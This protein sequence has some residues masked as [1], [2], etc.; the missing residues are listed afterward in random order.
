MWAPV[1]VLAP[2]LPEPARI[3]GTAGSNHRRTSPQ[4]F[5][6]KTSAICLDLQLTLRRVET[7]KPTLNLTKNCHNK[8]P[9]KDPKPI[10]AIECT[11]GIN[12]Q[13]QM[14]RCA[15]QEQSCANAE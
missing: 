1:I 8:I 9:A 7:Q 5:F 11:K 4:Y 2:L 10:H 12:Y 6:T 14:L 3:E 13:L 15:I